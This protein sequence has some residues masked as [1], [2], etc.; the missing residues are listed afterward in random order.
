MYLHLILEK[1][2][3][4]KYS[5]VAI[6][7]NTWCLG[8]LKVRDSTCFNFVFPDNSALSSTSFIEVFLF[9][10]VFFPLLGLDSKSDDGF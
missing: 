1:I 3:S 8:T 2:V 7:C 9:F 6:P 10:F 4:V 5:L